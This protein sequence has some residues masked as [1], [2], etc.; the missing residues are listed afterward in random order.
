M[1]TVAFRNFV[2]LVPR[3]ACSRAGGPEIPAQAAF[4]HPPLAGLSD[5]LSISP[6][7]FVPFPSPYIGPM[8]SRVSRDS[9]LPI[10]LDV[11]VGFA[12]PMRDVRGRIVRLGPVLDEVLSAHA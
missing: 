5:T 4:S 10:D 8:T 7:P 11:A 9:A 2:N 3:T 1:A 6:R 12:I